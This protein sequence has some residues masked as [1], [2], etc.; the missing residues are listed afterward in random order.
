MSYKH[1]HFLDNFDKVE[2]IE[3]CTQQWI[4]KSSNSKAQHQIYSTYKSHNTVKKL[5]ICA[6]SD[7][8]SYISDTCTGSGT[9]RFITED[10]YVAAQFTP[11]YSILF[12]NY[13]IK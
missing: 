13:N 12:D 1:I 6:K 4:K 3:D 5:L 7:S 10:N 11:A 2:G 8:I 9:D